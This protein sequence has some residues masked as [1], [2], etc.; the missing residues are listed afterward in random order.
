MSDSS[1]VDISDVEDS[2]VVTK[3][4]Q[5]SE[6]SDNEIMLNKK[7]KRKVQSS[8]EDDDDEDDSDDDDDEEDS[9]EEERP[10]KRG[11]RQPRKR[12]RLV[13]DFINDDV[14]VDDDD[15]EEEYIDDQEDF[16]IDPKEREEAEKTLKEQE[17]QRIQKNKFAEMSEEQMEEYFRLRH[18]EGSGPLKGVGDEYYDSIAQNGLLPDARSPNLYI[19]RCRM[20]E[21]QLVCLQLVKKYMAY[22][23]QEEPLEILSVV[24]KDGIKGLIY[25]EA[26]KT[27]HVLKAIE[28]ISTLNGYNIKMVPRNEMVD[29]LKVV[30][31]IPTLRVNSYCRVKRTMFKDD[32]AQVDE[33]DLA[34]NEVCLKLIPRIDYTKLRGAL[35]GQESDRGITRRKGRAPL[36]LFNADK[37]RSIGGEFTKDG[38]FTV[39]EGNRYRN[40]FLYKYFNI[41]H[42]T[43]DG[44]KPTISELEM[45]NEGGNE[46]QGEL[47][48]GK[49]FAKFHSFAPGDVVE[50]TEG[51]L[52]NLQGKIETI[53]GE[54]AY[55]R[56]DSTEIPGLLTVNLR[57]IRK[58]FKVGDHVLVI[59]GGFKG[60]TG[61]VV[62]VEENLIII[63]SDI[64]N[65]EVRVLPRDL[66][67]SPHVATGVDS[68]G[69]YQIHDLVMIDKDT[70]GLIISVHAEMLSVLNQH[71]NMVN[72][73]SSQIL[74]KM[75]NKFGRSMDANKHYVSNGS[76]V[77]IIDLNKEAE[78]IQI[79]RGAAFLHC[80]SHRD[81][82]GILLRPARQIALIGSTATATAQVP[83]AT[84][85]K[86]PQSPRHAMASPQISSNESNFGGAK[87]DGGKTPFGGDRNE[88]GGMG[89][90]GGRGGGF[91]GRGGGF[92]PRRDTS[93]IGKNVRIKAGP[94]KAHY[95]IV[96]DATETT[97]NVELHTNCKTIQ[98]DRSRLEIVAGSAGV[99]GDNYR[100]LA[101]TPHYGS[102]TPAYGTQ[103]PMYGTQ[104]PM[105]DGFGGRTPH[106][107]AQTPGYDGGRTPSHSTA[108]DPSALATPA[109]TSFGRDNDDDDHFGGDSYMVPTPAAAQ[110]EDNRD[111]FYESAPMSVNPFNNYNDEPAQPVFNGD[112]PDRQLLTGQWIQIDFK[113]VLR[114]NS[115]HQ[116]LHGRT[117]EV[118]TVQKSSGRV[119]LHCNG[120]KIDVGM[121]EVL[122][123]YPTAKDIE[124]YVQVIYDGKSFVVGDQTVLES[125]DGDIGTL[126]NGKKVALK[127]CCLVN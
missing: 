85:F 87:S 19:V 54:L 23:R 27:P 77:K 91:G 74:R 88:R 56:A 48:I 86:V 102:K 99:G 96:K 66:R 26:Y 18:E 111:D 79:Y 94:L 28:G 50:V 98:V 3:T 36:G 11:K 49:D 42:V 93:I 12:R 107:G 60:D 84:D 21:E 45:F 81:N 73:K 34:R 59:G 113:V 114:Q 39:F 118:V 24:V 122:P 115:A 67:L 38:D 65:E 110:L 83:S 31:D 71:G 52:V 33:V 126:D 32:L 63:I 121:E 1:D 4:E 92:G 82:G 76:Q 17:R 100:E 97:C 61:L 7:K 62:R 30:R 2:P 104:T 8:D 125:V 127:Y 68:L 58:F 44:I 40:G 90:R 108:W 14:E 22:S 13:N 64:N 72:L 109:H 106:Y 105:H 46:F 57:E 25:I 116:D 103:T 119:T 6:E 47:A 89:G 20:G 78:V 41:D 120:Q 55:M 80:R 43:V 29:T 70:F 75:D 16:G 112:I 69:R 117:L 53:D 15:D 35:R 101:R 123:A 95:G 37:I 5:L 10:K 124:A 9:E 51:E